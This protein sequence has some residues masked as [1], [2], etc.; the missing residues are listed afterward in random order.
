MKKRISFV[1][2]CYR[3]ENTI[4][5]VL[6]EIRSVMKDSETYDYEIVAVNDSSPDRVYQRLSFIIN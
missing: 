4:T 2:P 6:D 1:I 3:S 5:G